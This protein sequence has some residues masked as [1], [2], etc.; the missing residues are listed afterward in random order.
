[1]FRGKKRKVKKNKFELTKSGITDMSEIEGLEN[2]TFLRELNLKK[3]LITE[4]KGLEFLPNLEKLNLRKNKISEIKG[5]NTLTSLVKLNLSENQISEIKGLDTLTN[6]VKLNL[7]NNQISEIKGLERLSNLK[8]LFLS[9]NQ[10][11]EIKGLDNLKNLGLLDLDFNNISEI[12]GLE[13]LTN[14]W[15]LWLRRNKFRYTTSGRE[16]CL[17][18][19]LTN[20]INNNFSIYKNRKNLLAIRLDRLARFSVKY[21]QFV[22]DTGIEFTT[23]GFVDSFKEWRKSQ[24]KKKDAY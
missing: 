2:L 14:L 13:N 4:I 3:N 16:R 24:K 20:K 17:V 5:L 18:V 9:N 12:K 6:L 15:R 8:F 7:E 11:T 10:I 1:M 22:K 23:P 19:P 21:C